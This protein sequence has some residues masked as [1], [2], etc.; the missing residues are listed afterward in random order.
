MFERY[1]TITENGNYDEIHH[2]EDDIM[3]FERWFRDN[4]SIELEES[5]YALL[6]G[7]VFFCPHEN[8]FSSH[9]FY[10][11]DFTDGEFCY[12]NGTYQFEAKPVDD[13]ETLQYIIALKMGLI[14][15]ED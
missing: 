13:V 4:Y 2:S 12:K 9:F 10:V 6:D 15:N 1:Y 8:F 14:K 7:D 5:E 3:H 11:P